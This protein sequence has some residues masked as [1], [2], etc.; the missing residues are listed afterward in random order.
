[1]NFIGANIVE[2]SPPYDH[3]DL[4][5]LMGAALLFEFLSL[6]ALKKD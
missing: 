6:M 5:A 2:I 1:L 4:T 3:A